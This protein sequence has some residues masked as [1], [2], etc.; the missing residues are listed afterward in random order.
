MLAQGEDIVPISGTKH[1]KYL[2]ENVAALDARLTEDD[3]RRID[4]VIPHD[5]AGGS[6]YPEHMM[7]LVNQ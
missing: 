3:L 6:R 7:Q 4:E 5:A 2:E 1:R